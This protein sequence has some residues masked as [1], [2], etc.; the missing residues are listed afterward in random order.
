LVVVYLGKVKY[1]AIKVF[2]VISKPYAFV[3]NDINS[4]RKNK[5][6]TLLDDYKEEAHINIVL[7]AVPY[8]YQ[9]VASWNSKKALN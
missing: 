5:I 9:I 7:N 6:S 4:K 3:A 8:G 2:H 1:R